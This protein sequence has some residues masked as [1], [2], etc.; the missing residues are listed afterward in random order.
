MA[1]AA[2]GRSVGGRPDGHAVRAP[3]EALTMSRADVEADIRE[4]LGLA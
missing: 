3:Q 4:T 1:G 2:R